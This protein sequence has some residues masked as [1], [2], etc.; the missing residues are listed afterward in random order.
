M[1]RCIEC[2]YQDNDD[3]KC[4]P[5][6]DGKMVEDT[7]NKTVESRWFHASAVPTPFLLILVVLLLVLTQSCSG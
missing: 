6:C 5:M 4:C 1:K 2:G 7:A 3:I